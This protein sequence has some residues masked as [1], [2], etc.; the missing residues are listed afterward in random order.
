M[1][2][3]YA[4]PSL[5]SALVSV[6]LFVYIYLLRP[7]SEANRA[8]AFF[9]L[10][11][12]ILSLGEFF[13]R[14]S[15]GDLHRAIFWHNFVMLGVELCIW[16]FL[17][18]SLTYPRR[19]GKWNWWVVRAFL[20]L[21]FV[22]GMFFFANAVYRELSLEFKLEPDSTGFY[23]IAQLTTA[24]G[25]PMYVLSNIHLIIE[26][27][28]G[29]TI[30]VY[31]HFNE[32][33]YNKRAIQAILVAVL[34]FFFL[35]IFTDMV[36]PFFS[37]S[38]LGSSTLSW[39]IMGIIISYV[40]LKFRI[41]SDENEMLPPQNMATREFDGGYTYYIIEKDY[42]Q[43]DDGYKHFS[44]LVS[45]GY[46]GLLITNRNPAEIRAHDA[47]RKVPI[48][49]VMDSSKRY[50][51]SVKG[52][53]NT[54]YISSGKLNES[55]GTI[56]GFIMRLGKKVMYIDC[57][58]FLIR[59]GSRTVGG[60]EDMLLN[61]NRLSRLPGSSN[62]VLLVSVDSEWLNTSSVN[63]IVKTKNAIGG[64]NT[65]AI[66][67][68]EHLCNQ[69]VKKLHGTKIDVEETLGRLRK[70]DVLFDSIRYD[71]GLVAIYYGF[72]N[73]FTLSDAL[74]YFRMFARALGPDAETESYAVRNIL[75]SFGISKR[76]FDI[77]PGECYLVIVKKP[78]ECFDLIIEFAEQGY[79]VQYIGRLAPENYT[80]LPSALQ[81]EMSYLWL[82]DSGGSG[83]ALAPRLEYIKGEVERFVASSVG[84]RNIIV[85]DNLEY[86]VNYT[87]SFETVHLFIA[88]IRDMAMASSATLL[89]P[90]SADTLSQQEMAL[91]G[92]EL[93]TL[94]FRL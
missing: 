94:D 90:L 2:P 62:I 4:V 81:A 6:G 45:A 78:R 88:G 27:I 85:I 76:E 84:R 3:V 10:A 57:A 38:I 14:L 82:T 89:V 23:S 77:V 91:L 46:S 36:L 83:Y 15:G 63:R 28:V 24:L 52:V 1:N 13:T 18:F 86:L 25:G 17:F 21:S 42:N 31:K 92:K 65:W 72:T 37:I 50:D 66:Y 48:I 49:C 19:I 34:A 80:K 60:R 35:G 47:L 43:A 8:W 11:I 68:L 32:N 29:A 22:I 69:L 59:E 40:I 41:F 12:F 30:L 9:M 79:R 26:I 67:L 64:S 44:T 33:T 16:L 61:F 51:V 56:L 54:V 87:R 20:I 58:E 53:G 7:K 39:A 93:R 71:N 70:L 75:P 73:K 74:M 55:L 5:L